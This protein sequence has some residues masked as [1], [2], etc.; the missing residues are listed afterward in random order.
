[1]VFCASGH[2][3]LDSGDAQNPDL[4]VEYKLSR[5]IMPWNCWNGVNLYTRW[6]FNF[7]LYALE[8]NRSHVDPLLDHSSTLDALKEGTMSHWSHSL[9]W[10][11]YPPITPFRTPSRANRFFTVSIAI[12]NPKWLA[13]VMMPTT[14][15]L[16][17]WPS[18]PCSPSFPAYV[19]CSVSKEY[20]FIAVKVWAL[21]KTLFRRFAVWVCPWLHYMTKTMKSKIWLT[22]W[23]KN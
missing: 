8:A 14:P 3:D 11:L 6:H 15:L 17:F 18:H 2:F 12:I 20:D 22:V 9:E 5:V 16:L 4:V 1:M 7:E 10:P 23:N 13:L 19:V 21:Q